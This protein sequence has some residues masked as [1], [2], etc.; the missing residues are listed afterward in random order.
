MHTNL[1]EDWKSVC[2]PGENEHACAGKQGLI[3]KNDT[4]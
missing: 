1:R 2:G 4:A 3:E